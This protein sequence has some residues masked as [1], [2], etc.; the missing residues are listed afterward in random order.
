MSLEAGSRLGP[1]EILSVLG[2]GGMGEVYKARDTRLD[3]AVAVKVLPARVASDADRRQRFEREARTVAALNHPHICALYDIGRQEPEG[4]SGSAID[5]LVMELLEGETLNQKL[6]AGPL[7]LADAVQHGLALLGTLEVLH[8]QGLIHRD[9]KPANVFLT[10]HGLKLLDF[11]LARS[12]GSDADETNPDL[13]RPGDILGT[14]RYMA[15][16]AIQGRPVDA[17]SDLFAVGALLYEMLTAKPAFEGGSTFDIAHAVVHD[18]PP[19]LSGSAAIMA[20]D[21]VIHRALAKTPGD[22]F[23]TAAAMAR[24]LRGVLTVSDATERAPVRQIPRLIVLPFR[25][26]RPDPD[27]EFLAFS[28]PDAI[29]TSLSGLP[30]LVVRSALAGGTFSQDA[31]DLDA[32]ARQANVDLI[33]VG[34]LLRGGE[35]LQVNAQLVEAPA[36]TVIWSQRSQV[37]W[38]DIFQVQDELTRRIVDSLS[39]PLGAGERQRLGRDVPASA[40][41]YEHFLRGNQLARTPADW[42]LA[43]DLYLRCVEEDPRY[44]PAWA[45]LGRMHRVIAKYSYGIDEEAYVEGY[46][47]AEEAF[48]RA[49]ELNPDLSLTHHL[50]GALELERGRASGAML[51]LL[52]RARVSPSDPHLFA[53]LVAACR[54]CGLLDA[55]LAAHERARR[56]DPDIST[57]FVFSL[58]CAGRYEDVI[59]QAEEKLDVGATVECL[60]RLGRSDEALSR[61]DAVSQRWDPGTPWLSF[62]RLLADPASGLREAKKETFLAQFDRM[63]DPEAHYLW[64]AYW[65]Y[66]GD[67]ALALQYLGRAVS[68]GYFCYPAI[69][70]DP[71]LDPL[72]GDGEFVRILGVAE[73]RHTEAAAAFK[74][75]GGDRLV[76]L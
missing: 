53:G 47:K 29:T 1:Y 23:Q 74:D 28:L 56:L 10:S 25:M 6:E 63:I 21:R 9:L 44:A 33:L 11:G 35:Q 46:R 71:W 8:R 30:S 64:A 39:D 61:L 14:P 51:R 40:S 37:E 12:L 67:P 16:E 34:T 57:A 19:M 68:G 60:I 76:G 55:S 58:M 24:D 59:T 31:P 20:A 26:L 15:P 7:A 65:A 2:T 13:T 17:R 72:R 50:Y 49:L 5:F 66:L 52:D 4:D 3:R 48:E 43:R 45:R 75:A 73:A 32:I 42:T 70:Q 18:R 22:R 38:Q 54:Y 62:L 36:G 41:A 69:A 27:A